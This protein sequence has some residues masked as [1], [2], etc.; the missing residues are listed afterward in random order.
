M[1]LL[2]DLSSTLDKR[3]LG[4]IGA[5]LGESDQSVSR[6]M[7]SAIATV[8]GGMA[9]K[10]DDP[11]FLKRLLD[12]VPS[13]IGN[14]SW[15]N[16]AGGVAD[17]NSSLMSAG[18]NMI[19]SL[20]GGS[21]GAITRALGA[22]TGMQPTATSSMLAMA[23]PMVMSFLGRKVR[24]EGMSM[25]GLGS[26][27]QREIP[28]IRDTLPAGVTDLLW[29]RVRE[30]VTASPVVA[31]TVTKEKHSAGWVV[32]LVALACIGGLI[33][34][35]NHARRPVV[36][37]PSVSGMANRVIPEAP[38]EVPKAT[39]VAPQASL[40]G[41]LD[42]HFQTGSAK[43]RP[44]SYARLKI[45]AASLVSNPN[46]HVNVSGYTDNVGNAA[47]NMRLSQARADAVKADLIA[48]GISA[49]RLTSQGF[50]QD[51]PVADNGTAQGRGMNRRVEVGVGG[52]H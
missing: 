19:S 38:V 32:P 24:D 47:S 45:F 46:A 14:V 30:T 42:L 10:S 39:P 34:L 5:A 43:L 11:S 22:G 29:P 13:G 31:Q 20:F 2:T 3:S 8:L 48:Q 4:G 12:L 28:A 50:G 18:K 21:E 40:P 52:D 37:P 26:L 23:A 27:L 1:S 41:N 25:G 35:F 9:T 51:N 33:W 15:S 49:D 7:Q 17:P 16:L 44:E 36:T 6:G